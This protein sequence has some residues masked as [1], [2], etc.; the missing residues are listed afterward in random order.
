MSKTTIENMKSGE[1]RAFYNSVDVDFN[2]ITISGLEDGESAFKECRDFSIKNSSFALRYPFWHCKNFTIDTCTYELPTRAS[3][4]YCSNGKISNTNLFSV[5]ALRNCDNITLTNSTFNSEDFCWKSDNITIN[6]VTLTGLTPFFDSNSLTIDNLQLTGKYSFQ[7]CNDIKM[8]N[9][10]LDSKDGFW[11]THNVEVRDS[12]LIGE[13]L[14]WYSE[15]LTL[16]NCHIKGIQPLCYCK[17]LKM[18]NCTMEDAN[19]AFEY[20]DVQADIHSHIDSIKNVLSGTVTVDSYDEFINECQVY[21]CY[22]V[23]Q[24]RKAY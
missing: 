11:H 21:P 22:G 4:W 17:N 1:E 6:N 12:V 5:K 16:I 3:L 15:D 8:T 14:A 18:I 13:Y 2:N 23:V 7:Y 10:R 19:L 24:K 20:S 9:S